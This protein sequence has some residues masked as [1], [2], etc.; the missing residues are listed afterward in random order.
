[1]KE[2]SARALKKDAQ[3]TWEKTRKTGAG[4]PLKN[5]EKPP[6]DPDF[7]RQY[8]SDFVTDWNRHGARAIAFLRQS[9]PAAYVKQAH[10]LAIMKQRLDDE[11]AR[12]TPEQ[13]REE[14]E[15]IL[16][17]LGYEKV[18]KD[19]RVLEAVPTGKVVGG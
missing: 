13:I 3:K 9:N 18:V 8:M 1:M 7:Q 10:Q 4:R 2:D 5:K 6:P 14:M 11:D 17:E 12:K 16:T 15:S 19:G